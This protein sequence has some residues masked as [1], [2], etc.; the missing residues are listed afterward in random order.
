MASCSDNALLVD[1]YSEK[2]R[3][4]VARPSMDQSVK[5]CYGRASFL[6]RILIVLFW[7]ASRL[8]I[9]YALGHHVCFPMSSMRWLDNLLVVL[10]PHSARHYGQTAKARASSPTS[11]VRRASQKWRIATAIPSAGSAS[12]TS[13]RPTTKILP[14]RILLACRAWTPTM[15]FAL[16]TA[17]TRPAQATTSTKHTLVRSYIG[18]HRCTTVLVFSDDQAWHQTPHVTNQ[19]MWNDLSPGS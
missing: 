16:S 4:C 13:L 3:V 10:S 6:G 8:F 19:M 5:G 11:A 9:C 17:P 15:Q 2:E 18:P 7:N 1:Y 14:M 12:T